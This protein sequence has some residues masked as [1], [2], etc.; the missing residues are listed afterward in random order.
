[1]G[2]H[3]GGDVPVKISLTKKEREL[4][5]FALDCLYES[6]ISEL[7]Q[8]HDS[9]GMLLLRRRIA[10]VKKLIRKMGQQTTEDTFD[11]RTPK[12]PAQ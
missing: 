5:A 12:R 10:R 6:D 3:N 11:R 9:A 2:A 1:M 8:G 7:A 4:A